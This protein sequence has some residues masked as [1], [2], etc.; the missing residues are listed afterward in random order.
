MILL[1]A[2]PT[3]CHQKY[4]RWPLVSAVKIPS[5]GSKLPAGSELDPRA[6]VEHLDLH[7]RVNLPKSASGM[8]DLIWM[9]RI[10]HQPA[11]NPNS[12]SDEL[13]E[14]LFVPCWVKFLHSWSRFHDHRLHAHCHAHLRRRRSAAAG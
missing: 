2:A 11:G 4:A 3:L 8:G 13:V 10:K 5:F 12:L 14:I 1:I 9:F 7:D 6:A